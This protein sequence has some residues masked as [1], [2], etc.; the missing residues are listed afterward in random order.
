M[1][2]APPTLTAAPTSPD[3]ADRATFSARSVALDD[4]RKNSNVPEMT[5]ALA[6]VY[7]NAL[8]AEA[9]AIAKNLDSYLG[10]YSAGATYA[11]G[12]SVSS[13]TSEFWI[14][15]IAGN[16]GNALVEGANWSRVFSQSV[17]RTSRAVG[18]IFVGSDRGRIFDLTG[19]GSQP[20]TAAGTLGDGWYVL[21]RNAGTG[22]I[23]L[24]PAGAEQ[25]DGLTNYIMYPGECRLIQCTGAA[26]NSLVLS[27]FSV[28]YTSSGTF[29]KPPGY[30]WLDVEGFGAG[31]G[32]G[33][34]GK[35]AGGGNA[36][37]GGG[38][39]GGARRLATISAALVGATETVTIGA[40]GTGGAA[41]ATDTTAGNAGTTGGNTTFGTLLTAY[42]G[43]PG[44]GGSAVGAA[45]IGGGGGGAL[46]VGLVSGVGGDPI[47]GAAAGTS[48]GFG[49]GSGANATTGGA[50]VRGGGAGGGCPAA[51][52]GSSVH[53][54]GGGG[55][56][57]RG[58]S[59]GDGGAGG[60]R[61]GLSAGGGAGGVAATSTVPPAQTG[62]GLGGG[63][64]Y[65]RT[66]AVASTSAGAVGGPTSGGGGG[67]AG[68]NATFNSGAGATGGRGELRIKGVA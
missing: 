47:D 51:A 62:F 26:F 57:A 42:G 20:F 48:R 68:L 65:Y 18:T 41:Q 66:T 28:T 11:Q 43:G 58:V 67:G 54:G 25:I 10:V 21:V 49:G 60:S 35:A 37:G 52:G 63:G 2:T 17:N 27:P 19:T 38:G 59:D 50:S 3:R 36:Y 9:G 23:T 6:N 55:G 31:G 45:T 14:S 1:A 33:S 12:D 61:T 24:E 64:G 39:G 34:G 30:N 22:E 29:T 5:L 53:G 7:A 16:I 13:G 4:W 46:S 44:P 32:G 15:N 56:G 40:G 8:A